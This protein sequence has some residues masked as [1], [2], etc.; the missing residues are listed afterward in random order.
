MRSIPLQKDGE[1]SLL[2]D[3]VGLWAIQRA[4]AHEF[5]KKLHEGHALK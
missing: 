3:Q 5:P 4:W 1:K 2:K